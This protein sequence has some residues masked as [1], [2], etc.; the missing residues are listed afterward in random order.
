MKPLWNPLTKSAEFGCEGNIAARKIFPVAQRSQTE[1]HLS[2][3][4]S[5]NI[6]FS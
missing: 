4:D 2:L 5:M 1:K 3:L 6:F